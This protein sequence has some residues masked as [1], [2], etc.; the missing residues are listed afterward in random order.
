[1]SA[2]PEGAQPRFSSSKI[3]VMP[4]IALGVEYDGS[5][6][7]GWQIQKDGRSVQADVEKAVARVA[8][9]KIKTICAGRTDAGVHAC[10]QVVHFDTDAERRNRSWV[11][12]TNS[13]LPDDVNIC[14]ARQVTDA[15]SARFSAVSRRYRYLLLNR[16]TR[17]AI[18]HRRAWIVHQ[19]LSVEKMSLAAK[20]LVGE[21]DF[22]ALRA[23]GCQAKSPV[24]TIHSL[25]VFQERQWICIDVHANAF[26]QHMVRNIAGLLVRV[27]RGDD[28]PGWAAEVLASRDRCRA[29]ITAPA[30]GLY[31]YFVEYPVEFGLPD[32][33]SAAYGLDLLPGGQGQVGV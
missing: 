27:G 22:S 33:E 26:L 21:H 20:H 24:R 19:N 31:L 13:E 23:A 6:F 14:W 28:S 5:A 17:S 25:R 7:S 30:Q 15:F 8:D 9:H 3:Q 32:E 29:G 1:M 2:A 10:S 11:L 18:C 4:R 16:R 12:G